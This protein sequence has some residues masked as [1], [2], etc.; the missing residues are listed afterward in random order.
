MRIALTLL[1]ALA[2]AGCATTAAP[3]AAERSLFHDA[4]FAPPS[5]RIDARD[6]FAVSEAMRRYLREEIADQIARKGPQQGLFDALYSRGRLQLQYDAALTR[7]AAQAFAERAGNCLSLVIM[8]AALAKELGLE[9]FYQR[10]SADDAWSRSGET[11]FAST[12]VNITLARGHKDPRVRSD[13]RRRLTIDFIPPKPNEIPRTWDVAEPTIVAMYMNNRAA[14]TFAAG[15]I[16]DAYAWVRAAIVQDPAFLSAY[17]TL[18]VIYKH[19]GLFAEAERILRHVLALEPANL[20]AMQNLALVY[21]DQGRLAEA[22]ALGDRIERLQPHAP[23]HFFNLGHE[24]MESGD[25]RTAKAM[26]QREIERDPNY[27]E[28]HYGLA[29]AC[30]RLGE[31]ECARKHLA[32]A[33]ANSE[34]RRDHDL[35][36]A[37]LD[38]LKGGR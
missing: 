15:R 3:P 7:N 11:Y 22:D 24:A 5:E 16:D 25:Y 20:N 9:V 10:V 8:T 26:F 19:R 27:H 37:K 18:G 14:E 12:H 36:S 38:R 13:E 23:F 2:L 4:A 1:V 34:T 30:A 33:L 21:Q 6:V 35:Y 32:M 17:N 29:A 31:V 28:F